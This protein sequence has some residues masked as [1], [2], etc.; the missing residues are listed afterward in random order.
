MMDVVGMFE[1]VTKWAVSIRSPKAIPEIV[2]KAV[3]L[4]RREKPG[5]VLIE[6]PEDIAKIDTP[7][8]PLVPHR[9]RRPVP[10]P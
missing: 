1:P 8:V 3:R 6:L 7:E 4:A 5:A 2:R 9:H 10:D